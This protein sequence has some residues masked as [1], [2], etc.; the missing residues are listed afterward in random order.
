MTS[1]QRF[2]YQFYLLTVLPRIF[3]EK[4]QNP[5]FRA[6]QTLLR[7]WNHP[8]CLV[9]HSCSEERLSNPNDLGVISQ[10]LN[11][12]M[13]YYGRKYANSLD[14]S[15]AME[16]DALAVEEKML[17]NRLHIGQDSNLEALEDP[18][19]DEEE[20]IMYNGQKK[21]KVDGVTSD[22][23]QK[24]RRIN[25]KDYLLED[26]T[27]PSDIASDWWKFG[28]SSLG[29]DDIPLSPAEL[30]GLSN[31]MVTLF[32]LLALSIKNNDKM[33]VFSQSLYTLNVIECFLGMKN[34]GRLTGVVDGDVVNGCRLGEWKLNEDYLRIDGSISNRQ[35]IIKDFNGKDQF[36]L[37]LIS[38]K[39]GNMGI[40]LQSANRV[41]IF[42]SS[43][44]PVHDL[45][46]IFRTYR[47]GQEKNVFVYRLY[48]SGSMEEKI[49]K[50]QVVKQSL[51]ERVVDA[52]M[53]EN[54]FNESEITKFL[55]P[56]DDTLT[57][58]GLPLQQ[59]FRRGISYSF[60]IL[61][62]GVRD[63]LLC[64]LVDKRGNELFA[65]IE[66]HD[67]LLVDVQDEHLDYEQQEQ[68][69]M[70]IDNISTENDDREE[71]DQISES[72]HSPPPLPFPQPNIPKEPQVPANVSEIAHGS[73]FNF[74]SQLWNRFT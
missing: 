68:A 66:D 40:N 1:F 72:I 5:L 8:A 16:K 74:L 2:L 15:N 17:G 55:T 49:H 6:Y 27:A 11:K 18:D 23:S 34:W 63:D 20:E 14:V 65:A 61:H 64:E 26:L 44:N 24:R 35:K 3:S 45:Q 41:V 73:L 9:L 58:N 22:L 21:R 30:L 32:A 70:E 38:T 60:P 25:E 33:L 51:S 37:M 13:T 57:S 54:H 36:K 29:R 62:S 39:A 12:A 69:L 53:P 48:A 67:S 4:E 52:R 50:N 28:N 46:A 59:P 56:V 19:F 71:I 43:W 47:F 10:E 42:D 31:K 7:I